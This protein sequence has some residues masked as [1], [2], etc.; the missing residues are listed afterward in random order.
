MNFLSAADISEKL[1]KIEALISGTNSAQERSAAE[2]ARSRLLD[3][4]HSEP[5]EFR[6]SL[7][8][9]WE[10]QL[11][12]AVSRKHGFQPFR[13]SRQRHTTAMIHAP[14]EVLDQI[15]WPEYQ[16]VSSLFRDLTDGIMRDMMAKIFDGDLE[17][18][19][20]SGEVGYED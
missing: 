17:E 8:S 9:R 6:I 12:I 5:S 18:T 13:Y 10:K 14:R 19:V 15:I 1:A 11:F 16:Q 4:L 7:A 3:R 2:A 20:I